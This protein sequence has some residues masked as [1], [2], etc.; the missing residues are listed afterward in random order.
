[1]NRIQTALVTATLFAIVASVLTLTAPVYAQSPDFNITA[2]PTGQCVNLGDTASYT[3]KVSGQDGF[4]G[5]VQLDDS[6]DPNVSNGPTLSQIPSS[7]DVSPSDNATFTLTAS[8]TQSTAKQVYA[9]TINGLSGVLVHSVT[10]YLAFQPL[11]Y[12]AGGAVE[13]VNVLA[14]ISPYAGIALGI[15]GLTTAAALLAR[16]RRLF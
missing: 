10:V 3:I 13:P 12:T 16:R 14:V 5:T 7:V 2:N 11:C 4:Q 9:I 8:T 6:I 15:A 1:L